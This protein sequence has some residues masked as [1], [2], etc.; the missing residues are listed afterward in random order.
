MLNVLFYHANTATMFK[1]S[2]DLIFLGIASLYLKT[3]INHHRP[4]ISG[5][6][7]WLIPEQRELTD[8]E[9]ITICIEKNVNLLCTSHYV[10][11]HSVLMS[12]L[13]R[14]YDKLPKDIIIIA[15]GPSIDANINPE[16]FEQH[17][18]IKFAIYGSGEVAF[19]DIVTSLITNKKLLTFNTSNA[20]WFDYEKQ[21]QMVADFKYVPESSISPYCSNEQYLTEMVKKEQSAGATIVLPYE[22]TRGCPYECTFCDWNAGL[23]TK[24]SR[25]KNSYKDEINL[26]QKLK[27]TN[28]FLSDANV[29]QYEE[30]VDLV[31]YLAKKNIEENAN[32]K[33][34]GNFSK[35]RKENN[36]K[37]YHLMGK[38]N[39]LHEHIGFTISVQDINNEV[40]KNINRPDVGWPTHLN[41]I[42]ELKTNYPNAISN[43]QII[44]GLPGQTVTSWRETLREIARS[45]CRFVIFIH[46][47][48]PTSP[49]ARDDSYQEKFN[50]SYSLAERV[51]SGETFH[52]IFAESCVSFNKEDFI[53]MSLL[54][55]IYGVVNFLK[56][57]LSDYNIVDLI[58]TEHLV[59]Q[60]IGSNQYRILKENLYNNWIIHNKFYYTVDSD[61]NPWPSD[62]PMN[63]SAC[64]FNTEVISNWVED[65]GFSKFFTWYMNTYNFKDRRI[66]DKLNEEHACLWN[67]IY[68]DKNNG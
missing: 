59:D 56:F 11:N 55:S 5:K 12:Q 35:L 27:V 58:D 24:V 67:V 50:F 14:V 6:I 45:N 9:L 26:F 46:E 13:G 4:E 48:L 25:R 52:S 57:K 10:W 41:I 64:L 43:V 20:A 40:L 3:Y 36:L 65:L 61:G 28:L 60:F 19:A 2:T 22:L 62:G 63:R 47:L 37:I 34:D 53:D 1:G 66:N 42:N 39:L 49:A 29:G 30:D 32:F 51:T 44:Q 54:S 18:Y 8:H 17:P 15:G 16:F 33:I 31:A 38:G 21:K 7:N 23:S 68:K